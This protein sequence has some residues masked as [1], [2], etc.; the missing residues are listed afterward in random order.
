MTLRTD[1]VAWLNGLR[2]LVDVED[3]A[4]AHARRGDLRVADDLEPSAGLRLAD[5]EDGAGG[6]DFKRGVDVG[7]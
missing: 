7:H 4:L 2:R 1:C 5:G 6:A 3:L